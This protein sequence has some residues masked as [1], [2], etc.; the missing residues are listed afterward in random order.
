M[1]KESFNENW[2]CYQT[3]KREAAF[4][5]SL[6]HDAMLLDERRQGSAG[7]V[8]NGWIDAK[9]YTYEKVFTASEE[10]RGQKIILYFEGVYHRATVYLNEE[11]LCSHNY[12][13]TGFFVDITGKLRYGAENT[14]MV[15]AV[16]SDQPNSRWYSGT[17]IYR[18][19]WL[20]RL[21][22]QHICLQGIRITTLAYRTPRIR[23][24]V[25]S[26]GKGTVR[27]EILEAGAPHVLWELR[28]ACIHHD[29]G[30]LGACAYDFAEYRKIRLL[31]EGGY[32]AVRSAHNPC[33]EAMLRACDELG[34]LM[35]DEYA[36]MW[37]IHKTK[38]DYA[39][40]VETHY[41]EDLKAMVDKDYNHP[42]VAMYSTGNEVS[43]TAQKRGI[44]LCG[45]LTAC[46]HELDGTRPVTCGVNIFFNFLSSMGFGVY[47]DKKAEQ[48]VRNAKKKKAVGSEFFNNLAGLMGSEFMK[49]GATLYPCD[50]KTRDAFAA[51]DVAGYNYGIKRYRHDLKKY[52]QRLIL[53]SETFCSDAYTFWEMAKKNPRIIGD[54]V[55]SGMDYLGEVGVGSWEYKAYAPDFS[56]GKGWVTAGTGRIDLT[57][58][59]LAELTYTK[60]AFEMEKI[61]IGV[62]PVPYAGQ[63]H[64][65][66]AWKMTNAVESWS[67]RGCAGK[68]TQVEVY[69]RADHVSLFVNGEC[70]GT[71]KPQ[72]DCRV[73]FDTVYQDGSVRAVAYDENDGVI[74]EKELKTAGRET[75]LTVKPEC[76]C[77]SAEELCYVRLQFT[78]REGTLK[79][80]MRG[81][82]TVQVE[83]GTLLGLGSACPYY[84]KSYLGNVTDTYYGEALAVIKPGRAESVHVYAVSEHARGSAGIK[85]K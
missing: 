5:V 82:I 71:K 54:F 65:P 23:V 37:Y 83:G 3:G 24:Q 30:I 7:G 17:G 49:S 29:N 53:G 28:G 74:A 32:N 78:D 10:W 50:V 42:C 15:T 81:D 63:K 67:W 38:N 66:S 84:T 47:S 80:M 11:K 34:M 41:R 64:S 16:N 75:V 73:I 46:L 4:A 19:V 8:N 21:P 18:P 22:E 36:D 6:P 35:M 85:I 13:Y 61:G 12:G 79:P 60:V 40:E 72:N 25:Q 56:H 2:I 45:E 33:S 43:E 26:T 69:A 62:I 44:R 58:R 14:L 9:D 59:A 31:K 51:M 76:S 20:Y 48:A 55:W 70:V 1:R 39:T 68:K 57:G 77:V 27:V 52:P